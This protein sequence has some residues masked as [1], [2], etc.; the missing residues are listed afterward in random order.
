[1]RQECCGKQQ[2]GIWAGAGTSVRKRGQCVLCLAA[3]SAPCSD[4]EGWTVHRRAEMVG[5]VPDRSQTEWNSNPTR[6]DG[7]RH[8]P[9]AVGSIVSSWLCSLNCQVEWG[10]KSGKYMVTSPSTIEAQEASTHHRENPL[11][12][13]PLPPPQGSPGTT[14]QAGCPCLPR[15]AEDTLTLSTSQSI[16][17]S[18]GA[19]T[20]SIHSTGFPGSHA[21]GLGLELHHWLSLLAWSTACRW[22][23]VGLLNLHNCMNQFLIINLIIYLSLYQSIH[24]FI[25]LSSISLVWILFLWSILSNTRRVSTLVCLW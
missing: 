9:H 3:R 6:V 20:R 23:T 5:L 21:F 8:P 14:A 11:I 25:C 13:L 22:Q 16:C 2:T 12:A 1:M 4:L 17:L 15:D 18:D 19:T 24:L 7:C 10:V